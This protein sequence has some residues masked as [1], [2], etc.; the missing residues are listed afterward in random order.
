MNPP[1]IKPVVYY[2]ETGD[3]F[4]RVSL[5]GMEVTRQVPYFEQPKEFY[6]WVADEAPKMCNELWK[7]KRAKNR[8]LRRKVTNA[9]D[10]KRRVDPEKRHLRSVR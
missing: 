5:G 6:D 7:A 4:I 8:K 10:Q 2:N 3:L 9:Q 1:K